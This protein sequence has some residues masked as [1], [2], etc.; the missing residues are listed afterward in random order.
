M[1]KCVFSIAVLIGGSSLAIAA[2]VNMSALAS[3]CTPS[4]I[5]SAYNS[6]N[7]NQYSAAPGAAIPASAIAHSN[8]MLAACLMYLQ[9]TSVSHS[10]DE[11]T[12]PHSF[13]AVAPSQT[14]PHYQPTTVTHERASV[15]PLQSTSQQQGQSTSNNSVNWY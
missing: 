11:A 8:T 15:A 7:N 9:S 2:G 13:A 10:S 5:N 14:P 3:T 1:R 12:A 6:V 4:Y